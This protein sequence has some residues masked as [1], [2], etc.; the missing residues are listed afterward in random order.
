[1]KVHVCDLLASFGLWNQHWGWKLG[2]HLVY[3]FPLKRSRECPEA[4]ENS[5]GKWGRWKLPLMEAG[6]PWSTVINPTAVATWTQLGP[7]Q[8]IGSRPQAVLVLGGRRGW[9]LSPCLV[10]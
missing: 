9:P 1:M 8:E 3:P 7:G 5:Q 4:P 2:E 6:G 10:S